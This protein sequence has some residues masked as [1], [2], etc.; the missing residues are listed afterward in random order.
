MID[1]APYQSDGESRAPRKHRSHPRSDQSGNHDYNPKVQSGHR[2]DRDYGHNERANGRNQPER[3]RH[4][5]RDQYNDERGQVS[6]KEGSRTRYQDRD[7]Y[8]ADRDPDRTQNQRSRDPYDKRE[9]HSRDREQSKNRED[10]TPARYEERGRSHMEREQY[11]SREER[12]RENHQ[13]RDWPQRHYSN[14]RPHDHETHIS[15]QEPYYKAERSFAPNGSQMN[16]VEYYESSSYGG[17][18]DCHKCRYLCTGRGILLMLEVILNALVLICVVSSYFVLAGFSAG[19]A[20]GGFGGGY[21]PFEGQELQ[22]VRE[23]DQRF[24]VMR[25]P[26][27]YGGLTVSVIMGALTLAVLAAGSKHLMSLSKTWL[28]AEVAFCT[29]ASLGYGAAVGVFL[30]FALQI[31]ATDLC[32]M[33]ERLYARNGLTWMNCDLAG[34]DGGAATFGILLIILYAASVVLAFR[35]YRQKLAFQR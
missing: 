8:S 12:S 11:P 15:D 14:D 7:R 21:Y 26:L 23:L 9:Q 24:T 10:R 16:D 22:Q 30:H 34:T 27:L 3:S 19:M 32:K 35:A 20:G 25:A 29:L 6:H 28:W 33:R 31:N 1:S 17:I 18:L 2:P 5:E 13:E 4:R